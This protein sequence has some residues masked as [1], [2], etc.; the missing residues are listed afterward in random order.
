MSYAMNAQAILFAGCLFPGFFSAGAKAQTSDRCYLL[1]GGYTKASKNKGIAVY[2]FNT[3]TG[4]VQ[5]RSVAGGIEN[6][7]YL[8]VSKDGD[9][10]YAVSEKNTGSVKVY[11]FDR[12]SGKLEFMNEA[13]SGGRG[14]CYI[15]VDDA[16][17]HVFTANYGNGSLGVIR[18]SKDGSLDTATVES[19][20]HTGSSANK[21]SQTGPHAHSAVLSPDNRYLLS[22]NL[23]NDRVYIYHFSASATSPL[24]PVDPAYVTITPGSG[25]RHLCFHP[26]GRYVFVINE[27]GGSVDVFDYEDGVLRYKQTITMLPDGFS[28]TVEAA[29]IH[30]SPDGKYLYASNREVRNEIVIY[31]IDTT[32]LLAFAGRQPV[33]G[34]GPR[35][36]VIDPTGKFLLVANVKTNKVIVF[37]R[38]AQTGLLTFTGKRI[39]VKGPACLKFMGG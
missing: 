21:E 31:S 32:G 1:I 3:R 12:V 22:A 18:L 13:S 17:T 23:G 27:M 28:G 36:F 33:L 10:V 9:K 6:P 20:Q 7:S 25:P 39:R 24:S 26:N 30:I 8:A 2:E 16:G 37:R 29:D 19:I 4:D 11:R 14:P 15:S 34:A 38:D 5:F 35:N